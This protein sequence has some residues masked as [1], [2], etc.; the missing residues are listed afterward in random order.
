MPEHWSNLESTP[1]FMAWLIAPAFLAFVTLCAFTLT[2]FIS[3]DGANPTWLDTLWVASIAIVTGA[4]GLLAFAVV[5]WVKR[6]RSRRLHTAP[7]V[8]SSPVSYPA[9]DEDGRA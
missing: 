1:A 8:S 9:Q 6:V 5:T 7:G 3:N 4:Y 2:D